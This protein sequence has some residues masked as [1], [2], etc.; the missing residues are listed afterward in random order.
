MASKTNGH[1]RL[2]VL[3]LSGGRIF[4]THSDGTDKN[5]LVTDCRLPDGVV[6]D[7]QAGHLYWTNMGVPSQSDGSIERCDLDAGRGTIS[8]RTPIFSGSLMPSG[9]QVSPDGKQLAYV[10]QTKMTQAQLKNADGNFVLP[11]AA[12]ATAAASQYLGTSPTNFSIV[13]APGKDSAPI[14][15]YSWL[16]VYTDQPDKTK[17]TA[18]VDESTPL[19]EICTWVVVLP[20]TA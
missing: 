2:F 12:G 10:L 14:S 4:S 16:M 9:A 5:I 3:D 15:G 20:A 17:G 18:T 19:N 1:G 11:T 13:N 6:V 7:A 8:T